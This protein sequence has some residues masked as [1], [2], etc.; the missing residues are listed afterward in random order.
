MAIQGAFAGLFSA[1]PIPGIAVATIVWSSVAMNATSIS[2]T[3]TTMIA[4]W[5]SPAAGP[6]AVPAGPAVAYARPAWP[7][8]VSAGSVVAA[9][10]RDP[11]CASLIT[12][13]LRPVLHLVTKVSDFSFKVKADTA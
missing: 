1:R 9:A 2:G 4:R 6:V 13:L 12:A 11:S 10:G 5:V 3:S 8:A 7:G